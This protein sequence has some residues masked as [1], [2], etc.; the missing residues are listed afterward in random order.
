MVY[1]I[2]TQER[3]IRLVLKGFLILCVNF[4][5][6][7]YPT[8]YFIPV[9]SSSPDLILVVEKTDQ[10]L[11][12]II[13]FLF[14][15]FVGV[16]IGFI[17]INLCTQFG[18]DLWDLVG[19]DTAGVDPTF[20]ATFLFHAAAALCLNMAMFWILTYLF[21]PVEICGILI[22]CQCYLH[23]IPYIDRAPFTISTQLAFLAT[24]PMAHYYSPWC[25][26]SRSW[27][28]PVMYVVLATISLLNSYIPP[29]ETWRPWFHRGLRGDFKCVACYDQTP[30]FFFDDC[31]HVAYCRD[32]RVEIHD[33]RCPLC[34]HVS[35]LRRLL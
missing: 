2:C 31:G 7:T 27:T 15:F 5:T 13:G 22:G 16:A 12:S 10:Y 9:M 33:P 30:N 3:W 26:V 11:W 25:P 32:C 24:L 6:F 34:R 8:T 4:Y 18:P 21:H 28:G 19:V 1:N 23:P 14:Y 17:Y 20:V 29:A 35:D